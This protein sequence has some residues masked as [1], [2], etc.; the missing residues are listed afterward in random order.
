MTKN[1]I[2][3]VIPVYNESI[4]VK[5]VI[6]ELRKK[7]PYDNIIA[8]NDGSSDNSL[9]ILLSI[10]DIYVLSHDINLGQGA[11]LQTGIEMARKLDSKYVVT[12]DSDGQ[13]SVD[14]IEKFYNEIESK[15]LDI[16]I[17]SRFL[18]GSN[19][20]ITTFKRFF[21]KLSTLFTL[22]VSQIKLT[23]SHNGFRIINIKNNPNF[24]I[25]HNGMSHASEIVDLIKI[26]KMKYAEKEC[27]ILY[28]DYSKEKGQSLW[29]SIN[30]VLEIFIQRLTK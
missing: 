10:N 13:H 24:E 7:R 18:K 4:V 8:V 17:G 26:L 27:T 16:V 9:E 30:I 11:A 3:I 12:F 1:D 14:D 25:R 5:N 19:S 20:N 2:S 15:N 29:N 21:L 22:M 6:E 23:D 28:T